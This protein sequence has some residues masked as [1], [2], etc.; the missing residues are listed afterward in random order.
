MSRILTVLRDRAEVL[1]LGAALLAIVAGPAMFGADPMPGGSYGF[2]VVGGAALTLQVIGV[3]LVYRTNRIINFAQL[4]V[5]A[6]AG[7]FFV[8]MVQLLPLTR[9]IGVVCPPCVVQVS[10]GFMLFN[11][12][13][14]LML[15]LALGLFFSFLVYLVA[16]RFERAPRLVLTVATIFVA[17]LL[18]G[19]QGSIHLLLSSEEQREV[20]EQLTAA[21]PPFDFSLTISG[22]RLDA[23]DL[24]M[25]I[26]AVVAATLLTLYLRYSPTG[27]AIRA[28]A[29][30][31][32][33]AKSLGIS[34]G[35]VI[36]RVWLVAGALSSIAAILTAMSVG[37]SAQPQLSVSAL[38]KIL[39]VAVIARLVSLP[40]AIAAAVVVSLL[41]Q[42][43]LWHLSSVTPLDAGLFVLIGVVLAIQ[44]SNAGRA[45]VVQASG[46]K[47]S[48]EMRPIPRELRHLP[49]VKRWVRIG[50]IAG[51]TVLLVG[52]WLLSPSQTNL[53]AV[54]MIF[55]M[56]TL[57]VLVLTGW[58]GQISLGQ[59]AFAAVGG[60]IAA[61]LK[62]PFFI[63]LAVATAAGAA[64]AVLV[65]LPALKMR[66][67]HLAITTLA[68]A[69]ATNAILLNP[70]Y[71]GKTLPSTL[72]RPNLLGM[73]LDDQRIFY[74][75]IA[76]VLALTI[77]A[78]AGMRRS[79]IA[80]ALIAARDNE[81]AAQGFG[82]NLVRARLV[83]FATSGAIAA[84]AGALFA[85]HQ[86]GVRAVAFAPEVSVQIFLI[87]VIGGLGAISA[88]LIGAALFGIL[89]IASASPVAGFIATGGGGLLVL[90]IAPGGLGQLFFDARDSILRA[91]ARRHRIVVP[92][93][94]ADVRSTSELVEDRSPIAP[95][96]RPGGGSA[97]V[98]KRYEV[99]EQWALE[100]EQTADGNSAAMGGKR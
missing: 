91:T 77:G 3:V 33:R 34:T 89:T 39:A 83:A 49:G 36:G 4:Q 57:S 60:F 2:G 82:I 26:A 79:R 95:K 7:T 24:L 78:I 41:E 94:L 18:A 13:L 25:V 75:L 47:A 53:A 5:G 98:P 48:R 38:V 84:L 88:P 54:T 85:F 99:A 67:L 42:A 1:V 76:V 93:L 87:A 64:V 50:A 30:N 6:V 27:I 10:R 51:S 71:L 29:E 22:T 15:A 16:R 65:G 63:T 56:V 70:S 100:P 74:Y 23:A 86:H 90:M 66:G 44:R 8:A 68:F 69:A 97:F 55:A 96:V 58:A 20:Q 61:K 17:Q 14:S 11:Y 31:T 46:W 35:R 19:L 9:F 72:P 37:A 32:D 45:D 62:L 81:F 80:R 12:Y 73:D 40:M 21:R 28:A 52:P 43:S 59:F 92:S